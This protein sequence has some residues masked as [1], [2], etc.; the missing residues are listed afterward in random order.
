MDK[1]RGPLGTGIEKE[2]FELGYKSICGL[3]E[4]GRGS[5]VGPLVAGCVILKKG[6]KTKYSDSKLLKPAERDHLA[7][8]IKSKA[9]S[10]AVGIASVEEINKSGI[11]S[12]TYLAYH[13]AISALTTKPDFLL[14]DHYRLPACDLP[15]MSITFGDRLARAIS[16]ASIIAKTTRDELMRELS[17]DENLSV[18][19]IEKNY[20]YGT[21]KH[22]AALKQY[23]PSIH[24]RIK[25][26]GVS[27]QAQSLPSLYPD[28]IARKG[29]GVD[30][31]QKSR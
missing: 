2:L 13:R 24:H 26:R 11:Q 29:V 8:K 23:G 28:T 6:D 7:R 3:D 25:Y 27:S 16:A 22:R 12:A 19:G 21:A 15:K 5:W 4:A 9:I 30:L 31:K 20:G 10:W 18:Y 17:R 1:P 14:I